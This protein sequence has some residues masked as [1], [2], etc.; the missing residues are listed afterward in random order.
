M[1]TTKANADVLDLTDNYAF[2]GTVTFAN[3]TIVTA[4]T[5]A[6]FSWTGL[7]EQYDKGTNVAVGLAFNTEMS[8]ESGRTVTAAPSGSPTQRALCVVSFEAA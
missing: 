8:V 1:S 7:T 4:H 2:T 5:S 3:D 6:T